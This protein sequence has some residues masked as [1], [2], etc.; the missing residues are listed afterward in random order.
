MVSK[1]PDGFGDAALLDLLS[2]CQRPKAN[3]VQFFL[4]ELTPSIAQRLIDEHN[5]KNRRARPTR[6]AQYATEMDRDRWNLGPDPIAFDSD[7]SIIEGQHRL[8]AI[9]RS[10]KSQVF[11]V[12]CGLPSKG[13]LSAGRGLMRSVGDNARLSGRFDSKNIGMAVAT[14]LL[15]VD[16]QFKSIVGVPDSAKMDMYE[17]HQEAIEQVLAV[18]KAGEYG[19]RRAGYIAAAVLYWEFDGP[20]AGD[21]IDGI[22]TGAD[23]IHGS[24]VLALRRMLMKPSKGGGSDRQKYE[25]TRS[26]WAMRRHWMGC[27][28]NRLY[29][30]WNFEGLD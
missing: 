2:G 4:L 6:V 8:K 27:G 25:F 24:P 26:V 13:R 30:A 1:R 18:A 21:F 14:C 28:A 7:G 16:S 9:V 19:L 15:K 12:T 3:G 5:D 10:G 11:C 23:L 20:S 17:A 22:S 29:E